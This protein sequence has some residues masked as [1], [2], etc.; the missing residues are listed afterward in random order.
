[1][2]G[3][4]PRMPSP[5]PCRWFAAQSRAHPP[6]MRRRPGPR[7]S[8]SSTPGVPTGR[9][10]LSVGFGGAGPRTTS[11]SFASSPAAV[12]SAKRFSASSW[13]ARIMAALKRGGR[14]RRITERTEEIKDALQSPQLEAPAV[15]TGAYGDVVR[16]TVR[17]IA[18]MT[19][20]I[21]E[22]G[23]Q[24]DASFEGHPDAEIL[25]SLP[26]LGV[27]LGARVLAEFRG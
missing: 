19:A 15:L 1:M 26:G 7:D 16:S 23:G 9:R 5:R 11:S 18:E 3:S 22:L 21:G 24:L 20:Q 4:S 27:V 8:R 25:N 2:A 12:A 14:R 6:V 13:S 10:S 17:I